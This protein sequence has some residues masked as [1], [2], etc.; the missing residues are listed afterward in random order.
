MR[1][2]L[3]VR[4]CRNQWLLLIVI[5]V[6]VISV[7]ECSSNGDAARS[8]DA[9]I[10][11]GNELDCGMRRLAWDFA[12]DILD[13][14]TKNSDKKD[15]S[16]ASILQAVHDA[17]EL[18]HI[19]K[20]EVKI[21]E[22]MTEKQKSDD[23]DRRRNINK[24][25]R[26]SSSRTLPMGKG[27]NDG[28]GDDGDDGDDNVTLN[29]L[30]K[31]TTT[32]VFVAATSELFESSN[33]DQD[34]SRN[35]PWRSVHQALRYTR[36]LKEPKDHQQLEQQGDDAHTIT[37]LLRHGVHYLQGTALQL[38]ELDNNLIIRGFPGEDAWI[39]GGLSL[40]DAVFRPVTLKD[41]HHTEGVYVADLTDLLKGHLLPNIISL[42]TTSRRY[43]RAR[44]PNADP[45]VD[46]WGYSSPRHLDYSIRSDKV[47]E[48]TM[49]PPGT[50]PNFTFVDFAENPPP[51]VPVKN[52][53]TMDGYNQYASGRGGACSEIWGNEADSYWCSNSSQGG[54]AEVD[55]E[56]AISG[57]MQ[58]PAGMV[59]NR[60]D[61]SLGPL[62]DASSLEGGFVFA[63]H[64]QSWAMHMFE[65]TSHSQANGTMT[66]AKGGGKQ[67]GR[68]WCRCD[69]CTYAGGWCGQHQEPPRN[70]DTR[71]IGGNWMI[72]NVKDFLDQ[73][74]EYYFDKKTSHLYV[75]PNS[76]D[77]LQDLTIGMLTELIDLRNAENI[78]I[79][80]LSF[81]DQAST[82]MDEGWSA[83]SGG[84]WSLHRGG[85][86][87]IENASNVTISGCSFFRLDGNAIF[88][89]RKTRHVHIQRNH[90]EWLGENAIATWGDTDGYDATAG[91]YPMHTLIEYNVMRELGIYEKQSSAVGQSKAALTTIRKNIMFNMARAAINFN[92]LVGGGDVVEHNLIFN[93]CRESGDHG[94]INSWDRQP[95]L[96]S[97]KDGK[98]P[99]FDPLPRIIR[100]NFIIANYNAAQGV[101]NDDGSSWFHIH[102]NLFYQAE[103][104]KMDYGGHDSIYEYN[105]VMSLSYHGG[106]CFGM[107]NFKEGHGD[108]L[109]GNRCLLGLGS[110]NDNVDGS[111][112][113]IAKET[114]EAAALLEEYGH[115]SIDDEPPFVGRLWG[116]CEDSHVTL[117]SNEYYTPDGIA[118][119]GCNGNDFYKLQDLATKFGLEVNSTVSTLPDVKTILEWA[120]SATH[121]ETLSSTF[122]SSVVTSLS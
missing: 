45:E 16:N 80:D 108:V 27:G 101:D 113:N 74:G 43:F 12:R 32:C 73:P 72:E 69:Q 33:D 79:K 22:Q 64:S 70:D 55:R 96:T 111:N 1:S 107:G 30:C 39:S 13:P 2:C 44:F 98:T 120:Q 84:D 105:M 93:T 50:P 35:R 106:P 118:M 82:F 40:K 5:L 100:N 51:G 6:A 8:T 91:A 81:R 37:L 24:L 11:D 23:P 66:F 57:Q 77:D 92:D 42:F 85:A 49:P 119:V 41:H 112:T 28:G 65:I 48:W 14:E 102:H 25:R 103:G 95:F 60:S 56:C 7:A 78:Q 21:S 76:T 94:P 88:L 20:D 115:S 29:D 4:N 19:C 53:S 90:F 17:L 68:N 15:E 109:R 46:Q 38:S 75:K 63:W 89:S 10:V 87:F 86:I 116:G 36:S 9:G 110:G 114:M 58:L 83:P 18:S 121:Q 61:N 71:L 122:L 47:L 59:Y 104:F 34:G 26:P 62:R 99:S 54:W 31:D 52:D 97:L 3:F 67:G 117:E